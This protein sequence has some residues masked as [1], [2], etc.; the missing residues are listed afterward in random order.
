MGNSSKTPKTTIIKKLPPRW[1]DYP[2]D[3]ENTNVFKM[4]IESGISNGKNKET[5]DKKEEKQD[6]GVSDGDDLS[7]IRSQNAKENPII[8]H[9][10][11]E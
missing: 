9:S 5:P 7:P 10:K 6:S 8:I 3:D 4:E 11:T 1:A 2:S